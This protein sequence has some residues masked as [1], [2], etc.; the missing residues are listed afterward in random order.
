MSAN[1]KH[2]W[3][4]EEDFICANYYLRGRTYKEACNRLPHIRIRS[5][6]MKFQNCLFL[7]KGSVPGSLCNF[8]KQN[9]TAFNN[10]KELLNICPCV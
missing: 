8:S 5:I 3:L 4:L 7:D 10:V 6:K 2:K 9:M 1:Q